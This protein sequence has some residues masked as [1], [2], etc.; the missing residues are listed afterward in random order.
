M[1]SLAVDVDIVLRSSLWSRG[2]PRLRALLR[3]AARLAVARGMTA[4]GITEA[5][6]VELG[7]TLTDD[8]EQARLN[9]LYRR[10][11]GPTNVLSFPTAR[12]VRR[13]PQMPLILGDIVLAFE[14]T[15]REAREQQ[16]PVAD[17]L[18][19][20]VVHGVLHLLGFDHESQSQAQ[21]MESLEQSI[22]AELGVPDPYRDTMS[23]SGVQTN[24]HERYR[25]AR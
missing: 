1:T 20:L 3:K 21:A 19:H 12:A 13:P 15:A 18:R 14:T 16:K 22:L 24:P 5:G 2:R 9:R 6:R 8:R 7:I 11:D 25:A 17:H 10:T 23:S 4:A